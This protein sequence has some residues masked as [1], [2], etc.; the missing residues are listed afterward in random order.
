[1]TPQAVTHFH[2]FGGAGSGAAGFNDADPS[3]GDIKGRMVCVG[4]I[5]VDSR[6]CAPTP[7]A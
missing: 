4:G 3:I 6:A 2:L 5:D 1:M 7:S